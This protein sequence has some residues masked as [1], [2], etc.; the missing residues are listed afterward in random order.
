MK[1]E[2]MTRSPFPVPHN[3]FIELIPYGCTT[4]RIAEF[5]TRLVPWDL[6]YRQNM[7]SDD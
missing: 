2:K 3:L 4:L 7:T 1:N 5:P 6:E